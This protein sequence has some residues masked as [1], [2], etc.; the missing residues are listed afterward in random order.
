MRRVV[1]IMLITLSTISLT[2]C[3]KKPPEP[4]TDKVKV[5]VT[6][7]VLAAFARQVGGDRV[8]VT[9][10][11]S[12]GASPHTFEPTP[13]QARAAAQADLVVRIGL[14]ADR[15]IQGLLPQNVPIVTATEL[16]GIELIT[17]NH[18]EAHLHA[19]ANPHIW[20]DPAYAKII[21]SA[22]AEELGRIDPRAQSVYEKERDRYLTEL[23]SLHIRIEAAV[24]EFGSKKYVSFHP[25]WIYFALRYSLERVAVIVSSPG[26]EPTPRHLQEVIESIKKTGA[27]AVFAEP[28][29]SPKAA[30]VIAKEAG[31]EVLFLDPLGKQNE[32]YIKLMDRNLAV[33]SEAMGGR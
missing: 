14:D 15:W 21:C 16:E 17:E 5:V 24:A 1:A 22:I 19:G 9:T 12:P 13:S 30:Q 7:P 11:L 27:R 3:R 23:D 20:L 2:T 8:Q 31:V 28:Q 10:L 32:S 18:G 29:L 33:L 4:S 25:A 26:K 6:I